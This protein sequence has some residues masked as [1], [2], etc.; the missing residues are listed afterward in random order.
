MIRVSFVLGL[1]DG[2]D[3]WCACA[4]ERWR[5]S[6]ERVAVLIRPR[7][8]GRPCRFRCTGLM[9]V[10]RSNR[11][12]SDSSYLQL[13]SVYLQKSSHIETC[14]SSSGCFSVFLKAPFFLTVVKLLDLFSQ[15]T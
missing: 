10:A 11:S 9:Q 2:G 1:G 14:R 13:W 7:F 15:K 3:F 5:G 8:V 12:I 6:R 4:E